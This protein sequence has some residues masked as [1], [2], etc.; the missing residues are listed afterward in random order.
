[1]NTEVYDDAD[2]ASILEEMERQ[3][4]LK[5]LTSNVSRDRDIESLLNEH[6]TCDKCDNIIP[7]ERQKIIL[8]INETCDLCVECQDIVDKKNKLFI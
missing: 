4:A 7:I 5:T 1:M 3:L 6:L 2:I 8:S